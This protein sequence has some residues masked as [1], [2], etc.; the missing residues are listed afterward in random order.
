MSSTARYSLLGAALLGVGAAAVMFVT[1]GAQSSS[2]GA[3]PPVD[4]STVVARVGDEVI[5]AGELDAALGAALARL[6]QQIYE[7]RRQRLDN[8]VAERLLAREAARQGIAT[9]QLVE[10]EI[11]GKVAP[12]G[13]ADVDAFY[14]T[15]KARLPDQANIK[16]QIRAYLEDQREAAA[17]NAL[18]ERL[19]E[20]TPVELLLPRPTVRR[21]SVST[22]GAPSRGPAD[23]EVTLV[24][25]TD[26]H[27]PFCRQ[28]QPTLTRLLERYGDRVRH[29]FKD[30]PLDGLHPNAR[31][32]AEAAR[33]AN[34]Q[35][36]FWEYRERLFASGNDVSDERLTAIARDVGVDLATF[37]A[38]LADGRHRAAIQRD[39]EEASRLGADGTPAFFI[40]GR[41]LSGA[42]PF[43]AF[44]QIIEEELAAVR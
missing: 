24:E 23:A 17:R 14:E 37:T 22:E 42:Q 35:G 20:S 16:D 19:R 27:C 43:D 6:E 9:S 5:T 28:V 4:G 34:D 8:L 18:V 21:A 31:R 39:I 32:A 25:F 3:P 36:R 41:M 44:V 12:V 40:N 30:L 29:V 1:T 11:A 15:N 13:D 10:R 33:C 38:C 2:A 26:F 7:M